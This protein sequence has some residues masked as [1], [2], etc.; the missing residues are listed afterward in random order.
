M[1][2]R[3]SVDVRTGRYVELNAPNKT[4]PTGNYSI[5]VVNQTPLVFVRAY[6]DFGDHSEW[7]QIPQTDLICG[8]NDDLNCDDCI[9]TNKI[10]DVD[11]RQTLANVKIAAEPYQLGKSYVVDLGTLNSNCD[12]PGFVWCLFWK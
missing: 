2:P 9:N 12:E 11:C 4:P 10:F 8:P 6:V 1:I 7:F 5:Y 3:K